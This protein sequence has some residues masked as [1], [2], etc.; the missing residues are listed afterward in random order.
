[1]KHTGHTYGG[2]VPAISEW[3]M[4]HMLPSPPPLP[5]PPEL[6]WELCRRVGFGLRVIHRAPTM[7]TAEA[8]LS[9]ALVDHVARSRRMVSVPQVLGHLQRLYQVPEQAVEVRR[10]KIQGFLLLFHDRPTVDRVLMVPPV[11]ALV[12]TLLFQR[13][14]CIYCHSR[15]CPSKMHLFVGV[16]T[17]IGKEVLNSG[18]VRFSPLK[19]LML[20]VQS[21][22]Q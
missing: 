18:I 8:D 11:Q 4:A 12:L 16:A 1:M 22:S 3:G 10:Y 5:P 13:R 20:D 6:A 14:L 19:V 2:F 17:V 9:N 7:D 15:F 21:L